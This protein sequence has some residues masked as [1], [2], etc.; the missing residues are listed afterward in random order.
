VHAL[1]GLNSGKEDLRA[2]ATSVADIVRRFSLR[3]GLTRE[4]EWL[5][6]GLLRKL[7]D[8]GHEIKTEDLNY[9]LQDYYR[10]HAWNSEGKLQ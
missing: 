4:D 3:E 9:M 2:H 1:T 6:K 5:S 8:T 10:L 7:E